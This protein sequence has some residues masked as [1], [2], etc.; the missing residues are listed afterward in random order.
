MGCSIGS[1]GTA[2][3]PA[4]AAPPCKLHWQTGG[5]APCRP[6]VEPPQNPH[7]GWLA[8]GDACTS[9]PIRDHQQPPCAVLPSLVERWPGSTLNDDPSPDTQT[10]PHLFVFSSTP[11][12][13]LLLRTFGHH[14]LI[15]MPSGRH[16]SLQYKSY[17][18]RNS[19]H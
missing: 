16:K 12:F 13:P 3:E 11:F 19:S 9:Q 4:T 15:P 7:S 5:Q 2:A 14:E 6:S 8:G 18:K 10:P 1:A 17:K